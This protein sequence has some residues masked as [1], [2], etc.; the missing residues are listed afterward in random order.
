[1]I[2]VKPKITQK[3]E[4]DIVTDDGKD[5]NDILKEICE[6]A[7]DG[8]MDASMIRQEVEGCGFVTEK[9]EAYQNA[10]EICEGK[11]CSILDLLKD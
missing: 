6:I 9:C 3:L 5:I 10:L 7:H 2:T 4:V 8:L 11:L 1:M